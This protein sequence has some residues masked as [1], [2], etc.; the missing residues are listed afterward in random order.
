MLTVI[1]ASQVHTRLAGRLAHSQP[2]S[3]WFDPE[4]GWLIEFGLRDGDGATVAFTV[5]WEEGEPRVAGAVEVVADGD[6]LIAAWDAKGHLLELP[7]VVA[8]GL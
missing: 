5:R 4:V 6:R 2:S 3:W 8:G 1:T 7:G